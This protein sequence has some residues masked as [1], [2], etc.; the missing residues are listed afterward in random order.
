MR[1]ARETTT[2]DDDDDTSRQFS[3]LIRFFQ[4]LMRYITQ[5]TS[6][7]EDEDDGASRSPLRPAAAR[8]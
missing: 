1:R 6:H 2:D 5:Q 3:T 4:R 7:D 8:R